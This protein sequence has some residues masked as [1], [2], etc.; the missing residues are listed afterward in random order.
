MTLSVIAYLR[1]EDGSTHDLIEIGSPESM[2]GV[3]SYRLSFYGS[4]EMRA[5]GATLLPQLHHTDLWVEKEELNQLKSE[6]EQALKH[7]DQNE[8]YS[9]RLKNILAAINLAKEKEGGVHIG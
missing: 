5:L 6:V 1:L 2:A 9:H 3:E 8:S 4:A 7:F